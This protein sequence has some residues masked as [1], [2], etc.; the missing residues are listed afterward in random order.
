MSTAKDDNPPFPKGARVRF[1][2]LG[3]APSPKML[4]RVGTVMKT[5]IGNKV[6]VVFDGSLTPVTIHRSYLEMINDSQERG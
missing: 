5:V 4:M 6:R 1:N 2:K 3:T